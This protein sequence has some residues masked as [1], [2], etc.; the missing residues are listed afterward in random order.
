MRSLLLLPAF[1]VLSLFFGGCAPKYRTTYTY[2]EPQNPQIKR[3]I[4]T[5]EAGRDACRKACA[6][7]FK[8][9][10]KEAEA[11]GKK[12]YE[13]KLQAYYRNLEAYTAQLR[14][15]ELERDLYY[16]N[17]F[18]YGGGYGY[19]GPFY[20]PFFWEPSPALT[21]PRPVKPNLQDEILQ[22]EL[23]HCRVDCGCTEKFDTCYEGCGGKI[24]RKKV[25]IENCPK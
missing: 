13:Q 1:V 22:A 24:I 4:A 21:L 16:D 6:T 15:Y 17:G 11:I 19:W 8:A 5:C 12:N 20:S 25:C 14:R 10:R 23:K 18:Y 7:R 9:C 2:I 3:C